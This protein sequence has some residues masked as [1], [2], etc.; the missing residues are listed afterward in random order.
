[1]SRAHATATAMAKRVFATATMRD[2]V[3]TAMALAVPSLRVV[4]LGN[5]SAHLDRLYRPAEQRPVHCTPT[6]VPTPVSVLKVNGTRLA[7]Q[8]D[9]NKV[10]ALAYYKDRIV[11]TSGI[12]T[13]VS[14]ILGSYYVD[15]KPADDTYSGF[16]SMQCYVSGADAVTSVVNGQP[17]TV[18]GRVDDQTLGVISL[19]ECSVVH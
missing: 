17:V 14:D 15:L 5:G 3:G 11:Q 4:P 7:E 13:N 10:T 1:M 19:K 18:R 9:A 8:F 2:L 6:V 12:A 16:T